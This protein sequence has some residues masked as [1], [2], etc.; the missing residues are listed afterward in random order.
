VSAVLVVAAAWCWRILV[1]AVTFLALFTL[2]NKLYLV[3][4]P[5]FFALLL[6]AL[7]HPLVALLRRWRL[8]RALATWVTVI[9]AFL[10]LGGVGWFVAQRATSNYQQL[11]NQVVDLVGDLRVSIEQLPFANPDQLQQLQ[12]QVVAALKQ[13][14]GTIANEVF[15]VGRLAGELVT[16]LILTFFI[17]FFFLDE[18]DRMWS[19]FVRLLPRD[20]QPSVRGAGY[21]SW[22]V[23]SGWVVGTAIIAAFHGTVI[24]LVLFLLGVPLALPLAVLVFIGSFIPLNGA[25][26]FGGL[27]VLVTLVTQGP[28]AAVILLGVLLIE[29]QIEAHLLQPF[30]VGRAVKL[31]PVAIVLA[32][33]AG[34]L[35][36]GLFGAILAIPIVASLHAAVKYLTGVEDLDGNPHGTGPDRMAPEPPP[37]YAPLPLYASRPRLIAD[38]AETDEAENDETDSKV[39]ETSEMPPEAEGRP[40]SE[41]PG[42]SGP[43]GPD[44]PDA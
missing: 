1:V 23:L 4:L 7:L 37:D 29:N 14:S 2:F 11:V 22:H 40:A 34:G 15:T 8:P 44:G 3:F 39:A 43:T 9:V 35:T 32:L 19:W 21:R 12:Q 31:H 17:T 20:V 10:V 6:S 33:T 41:P 30:I 25:L 26:L 38:R 24:G 13:H 16:G 36:A 18:G 27:A 5:V 28:L 42:P